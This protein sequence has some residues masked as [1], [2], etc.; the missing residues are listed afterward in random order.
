[1]SSTQALHQEIE[2]FLVYADM[3]ATAFGTLAVDDHK[4]VKRLRDG[5]TVTLQTADKLRAFME[6]VKHEKLK[7]QRRDKKGEGGDGDTPA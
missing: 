5:K 7:E 4:I 6:R 2:N 1:M 3:S